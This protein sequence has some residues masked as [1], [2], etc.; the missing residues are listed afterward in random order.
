MRCDAIMNP[1]PPTLRDIDSVGTATDRLIRHRQLSLPV[2][3]A[4]G[5][6]V[7]MFGADE[8]LGLMVPRVAIAGD[9]APNVRFV[10]DD[11]KHLVERFRPLR[12]QPVG[13]IADKAAVVLAPDTP[14]IEAFRIFCH[15][16]TTL[17]VVDPESRKLLGVV[18]CW[19]VM[20]AMTAST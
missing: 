18:S 20:G 3:D 1:A 5:R 6:Y 16:R 17:A 4:E 10:G 12:E 7:G 13:A 11:P 9:L 19:D 8:L 15:S 2:V 14:Q